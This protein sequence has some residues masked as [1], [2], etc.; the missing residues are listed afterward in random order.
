M[1][2]VAAYLDVEVLAEG[3]VVDGGVVHNAQP[4]PL[5]TLA[6]PHLASPCL[7]HRDNLHAL[8]LSLVYFGILYPFLVAFFQR[9]H[10]SPIL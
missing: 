3:G 5:A 9:S 8:S 10:Y 2:Q 6:S 7:H 4:V 1:I